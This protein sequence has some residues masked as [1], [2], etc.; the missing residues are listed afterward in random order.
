M[1]V[2]RISESMVS[3]CSINLGA[4]CNAGLGDIE[5]RSLISFATAFEAPQGTIE[6]LDQQEVQDIYALATKQLTIQHLT[7]VRVLC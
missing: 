5:H 7:E 1:L 3:Y 4:D 6:C 2:L